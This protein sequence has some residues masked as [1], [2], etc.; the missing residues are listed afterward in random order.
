MLHFS[1]DNFVMQGNV[2]N[3]LCVQQLP[4]DIQCSAINRCKHDKVS[5]FNTHH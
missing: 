2:L 1:A 3:R 4:M 5:I